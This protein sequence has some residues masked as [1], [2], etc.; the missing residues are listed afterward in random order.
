VKQEKPFSPQIG[1][2]KS[3]DP[4]LRKRQRTV[5]NF[6]LVHTQT[7][8]SAP[9]IYPVVK[10]WIN[11]TTTTATTQTDIL[12]DLTIDEPWVEHLLDRPRSPADNKLT[13]ELVHTFWDKIFDILSTGDWKTRICYKNRDST[14]DPW[15]KKIV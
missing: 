6:R 13:N 2:T 7:D 3:R 14:F 12:I 15:F 8:A 10:V 11:K 1:P 4:N 5:V 9:W